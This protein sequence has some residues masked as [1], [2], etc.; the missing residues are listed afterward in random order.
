MITPPLPRDGG[1]ARTEI[2]VYAVNLIE[3][4]LGKDRSLDKL[5][6]SKTIRIRKRHH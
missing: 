6:R 5:S 2:Q 3:I 1:T 4:R